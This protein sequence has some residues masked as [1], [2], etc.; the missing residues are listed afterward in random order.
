MLLLAALCRRSFLNVPLYPDPKVKPVTA[1]SSAIV[2]LE[3]V[4][5]IALSFYLFLYQNALST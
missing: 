2:K 5:S 1:P 4:P 3:M